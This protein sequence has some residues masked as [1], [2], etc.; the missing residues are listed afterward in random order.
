MVDTAIQ[1]NPA[2]R[3]HTIVE[4]LKS[5]KNYRVDEAF[6]KVLEVDVT[7]YALLI[8]RIGHV[9]FLVDLSKR[10]VESI[11]GINQE[12][13][14]DPI[15]AVGEALKGLGFAHR[16]D[17]TTIGKVPADTMAY[18]DMTAEYLSLHAPEPTISEENQ[19]KITTSILELQAEI[20]EQADIPPDL[21]RYVL[22]KLDKLLQAIEMYQISGA[23][24]VRDVAE[25]IIGASFL[26]GVN[27][28]DNEPAFGVLDSLYKLAITSYCSIQIVNNMAQLPESLGKLSGLLG[29]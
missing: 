11:H 3:L 7:D 27:Y 23:F 5:N 6:A 14:I 13:Y 8:K 24:P 2:R 26:Q 12:K 20:L 28:Q 19:E 29:G 4:Q 21:K 15:R 17:Q 25:S 16:V 18:L 1:N 9:Y 10:A 22:E